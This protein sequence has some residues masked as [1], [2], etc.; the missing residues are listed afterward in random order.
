VTDDEVKEA[1][2][3]KL[4]RRIVEAEIESEARVIRLDDPPGY[5]VEAWVYL[6]DES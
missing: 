6:M 2:R 3:K 1:A 5:A 4:R